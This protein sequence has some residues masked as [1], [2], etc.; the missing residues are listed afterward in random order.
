M[1]YAPYKCILQP[2]PNFGPAINLITAIF[3][4]NKIKL[5]LARAT[6]DI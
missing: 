1:G 2:N 4:N 6:G 3:L 5:I